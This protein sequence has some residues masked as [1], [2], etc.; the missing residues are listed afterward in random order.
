MGQE[1][2]RTRNREKERAG[3]LTRGRRNRRNRKGEESRKKQAKTKARES[4]PRLEYGF[5]I[6]VLKASR[7]LISQTES[8]Q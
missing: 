3:K 2:R 5:G 4:K 6:R 8:Q 7:R 1:M